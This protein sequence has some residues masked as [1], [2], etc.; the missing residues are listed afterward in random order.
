MKTYDLAVIG[1]GMGGSMIASVNKDKN[2][3]LF[4]KDMNLGGCASTFK[5]FGNY[6]NAGAT[7]FV[8]YE[9]NHPIKNIFQKANFIPDITKSDIAIRI[10]QKD[11]VIDR[12][13]DFDS[14]L[15]SINKIYPN[16]N[17]HLFWK[18]IKEIDE[19]FWELNHLYYSKYSLN[20]YVKTSYSVFELLC[21][22]KFD[23]FKSAN[24]FISQT[25]ENISK[26]YQN[27]IDAQ[28]LITI[29]TTSKDVSLLS[30]CLGLAYPF[31]DVFYVNNGM[32]SLFDGLLQDIEV[33]KK[34]EIKKIIKEDKYYRLISNKNEYLC[35]NIVLNS[36]IFDSSKLFEDE[37]IKK[38]YDSFSYSDQSAF[39]INLT[40]DNK[41]EFLHHYQIIL[42]NEIP[43][44]IS[45]SFF[46]SF[47]SKNDEKMSKNGYSITISTHTKSL[48]WKSLSSDEYIKQKQITQDYIIKHFL[49]YFDFIKKE[50]IINIFSATSTTFNKY[51]NRYN[52]GGKAITIKNILEVPSCK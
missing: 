41:K 16:K 14:F 9:N 7:T 10:I 6:F 51:I 42:E 1:S 13:K 15:E 18:T 32:G 34:E 19:K 23:L 37:D 12:V 25:L 48:F 31:H 40:L 45:N 30:L 3:V 26:E 4:E 2:T 43:N 27:F 29:Q 33:R 35:Q 46:I 52:C 28:L 11:T 38:Y 49:E 36:S 17:N 24:K 47:S 39:V 50:E 8:G 20:S 5:R 21:S 44:A 22:F